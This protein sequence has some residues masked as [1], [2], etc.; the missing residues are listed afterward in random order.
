MPFLVLLLAAAGAALVMGAAGRGSPTSR[1][2]GKGTSPAGPGSPDSGMAPLL[3]AAVEEAL[4]TETDPYMLDAF[5]SFLEAE[6]YP[7]SAALLRT[8]AGG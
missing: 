3:W 1:E 4:A 5:A 7:K 2:P 6:G 8:K